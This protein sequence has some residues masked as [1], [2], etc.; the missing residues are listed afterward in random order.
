MSEQ[1]YLIRSQRTPNLPDIVLQGIDDTYVVAE[2]GG[3]IPIGMMIE[4]GYEVRRVYVVQTPR[5]SSG[6]IWS[7]RRIKNFADKCKTIQEAQ[8][9]A[10]AMT[11][12][13]DEY[14]QDR[15]GKVHIPVKFAPHLLEMVQKSRDFV[16]D[17]L[18]RIEGK[19]PL[20]A[21]VEGTLENWRREIAEYD[22]IIQALSGQKLT[23]DMEKHWP[24]LE[25]VPEGRDMFPNLAVAG[26]KIP[27]EIAE[28]L[29]R[30]LY[31][32]REEI[33]RAEPI[34]R[35]EHIEKIY[36][37]REWVDERAGQS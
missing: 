22:A 13:R 27:A 33:N 34:D 14:E 1:W 28:T 3:K 11:Q 10:A 17:L 26:L 19:V 9:M 31:W 37:A 5:D 32:L 2:N 20:T 21:E 16:A 25:S 8:N 4:W 30:G 15:T 6:L 18:E 7:D 29:R 23:A 12:V 35:Q 36:A 24:S